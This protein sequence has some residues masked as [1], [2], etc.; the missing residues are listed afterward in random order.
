MSK[1]MDLSIPFTSF[2]VSTC[3]CAKCPVEKDSKCAKDQWSKVGKTVCDTKPLKR[4]EI[5]AAYCATGMASCP[6][7]DT[8]KNCIC[9]TCKIFAKHG[10]GDRMPPVGYYCR[11]GSAH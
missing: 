3:Q 1:A 11:D 5:A 8:S 9:G 7:L 6:D 10:L 4:E 2:T